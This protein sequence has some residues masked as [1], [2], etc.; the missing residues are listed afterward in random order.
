VVAAWRDAPYFSAE[1]AALALAEAV[2]RLSDRADPVP[3]Q[4]WEEARRHYDEPTLAALNPLDRYDERPESPECHLPA[5][6]RRV[7]E[8]RRGTE[9]G[10]EWLG[11]PLSGIGSAI[12]KPGRRA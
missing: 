3:D 5:G 2:T 9:M 6:C 7:G 12:I 10:G 11:R 4:I 8:I 1:R